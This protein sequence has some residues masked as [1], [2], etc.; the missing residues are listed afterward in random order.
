MSMSERRKCARLPF[1]P[2]FCHFFSMSDIV[3]HVKSASQ[4]ARVVELRQILRAICPGE[5]IEIMGDY[6]EDLPNIATLA[7]AP[8]YSWKYCWTSRDWSAAEKTHFAATHNGDFPPYNGEGFCC[9]RCCVSKG[10]RNACSFF[11]PLVS[12]ILMG[13]LLGTGVVPV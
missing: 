5:I 13:F 2:S 7:V 12:I 11:C 6:T 9:E 1:S 10:D 3:L 4:A 8:E